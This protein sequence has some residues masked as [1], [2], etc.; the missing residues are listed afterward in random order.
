MSNPV[1][2]AFGD[3]LRALRVQRGLSQESLAELAVLHR[4]YLGGVERGHR[5]PTLLTLLKIAEALQTPPAEL[6]NYGEWQD[7]HLISSSL[8]RG[9]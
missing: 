3:H 5:N 1:L 4:T 7:H 8:D 6:L 9:E 2:Q